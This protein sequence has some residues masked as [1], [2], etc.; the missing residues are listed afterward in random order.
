M[1]REHS[2]LD[3][4]RTARIREEAE[5]MAEFEAHLAH[6][7]DDLVAD[8]LSAHDARKRA[9]AEFGDAERLKAESRAIRVHAPVIDMDKA[10]LVRAG[11]RVSAPVELAWSC[12]E[13]GPEPCGRCESCLRRAR[14]EQAALD[15]PA[16]PLLR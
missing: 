1:K 4:T 16:G 12:Y 14:A 9:R 10:E 3:E 13:A 8:G 7:V 2:P 6:R 11:R 5:L 15:G